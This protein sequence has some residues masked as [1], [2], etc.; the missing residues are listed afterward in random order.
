MLELVFVFENVHHAIMAEKF[1]LENQIVVKVMPLP[2]TI[3]AGCGICLRIAPSEHDFA[4]DLLEQNDIKIEG[5]YLR[6]QENHRSVYEK[7][8]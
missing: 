4:M 1:M 2:P 8:E 6:R 5:E 3:K 7:L